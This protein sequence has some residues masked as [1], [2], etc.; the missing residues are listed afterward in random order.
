MQEKKKKEKSRWKKQKCATFSRT[1][2]LSY[3]NNNLDNR[4]M[5]AVPVSQSV[6]RTLFFGTYSN[7]LSRNHRN[8][9]NSRREACP[10][11][12]THPTAGSFLSP[13]RHWTVLTLIWALLAS[14]GSVE[15]VREK[16]TGWWI[17]SFIR[18]QSRHIH[19]SMDA[20]WIIL[21]HRLDQT[22]GWTTTASVDDRHW[23]SVSRHSSNEA[24]HCS[25]VIVSILY[26]FF[27]SLVLLDFE[28]FS[29]ACL[30]ILLS[31]QH[32]SI[33]VDKFITIVRVRKIIDRP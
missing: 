14:S 8:P 23:S 20:W 9:I 33:I 13:P 22:E 11:Y 17:S 31:R 29:I 21:Q 32:Q 25:F 30:Y 4:S 27:P 7:S 28:H 16:N 26:Y 5:A 24:F 10:S 19:R 1:I 18:F 2:E 3:P 15:T 6:V 12:R